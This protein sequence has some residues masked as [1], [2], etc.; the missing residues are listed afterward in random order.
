[1]M[2][3][4]I[5]LFTYSSK[6]SWINGFQHWCSK[7]M[8]SGDFQ[9]NWCG[10]LSQTFFVLFILWLSCLI[11]NSAMRFD[12]PSGA[13]AKPLSDPGDKLM[14]QVWIYSQLVQNAEVIQMLAFARWCFVSPKSSFCS[15]RD[16][17]ER[18]W[19]WCLNFNPFLALTLILIAFS[20]TSTFFWT[21]GCQNFQLSPRDQFK[22][23]SAA[24]WFY[25]PATWFHFGSVT[26]MAHSM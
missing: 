6:C 9:R 19:L 23:C 10:H 16:K 15:C 3:G 5:P 21:R 14:G 7:C 2:L 12:R 26:V 24:L 17:L 18:W 25:V 13:A 22:S 8:F 1:M 11:I 4:I 20:Q